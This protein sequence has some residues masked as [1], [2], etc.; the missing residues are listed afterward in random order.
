MQDFATGKAAALRGSEPKLTCSYLKKILSPQVGR[1]MRLTTILLLTACLHVGA[2]GVTQTVSLSEKNAP[3]IKVMNEIEHQTGYA[4]FYK[5]QWLLQAK[6][7]TIKAE[8]IPLKQALDLC[9]KDQPFTYIISGKN[10]S[11]TPKEIEKPVEKP[12]IDI[13]GKITDKDGNPLAGANVK[14]K[15]SNKGVTTNADGSF[16]LKEV[17]ENSVLEIS[18]VGFETVFF[19]L[20]GRTS[21]VVTLNPKSSFLDETIVIAYGTTTKRFETGNISKVS[22]SEIEKQPVTNPLLALQGRVPGLQITQTSGLQ[23]SG[24]IV[25]IQ[26]QNSLQNGSNPLYVVDGVPVT[27]EIP[28]PGQTFGPLGNS[29]EVDIKNPSSGRGNTLNF[30][31]PSDIESIEVL[32]DADAT[33]IYGSR[34]AN[35]AILITTKKGKAGKPSVSANVQKGWGEVGHFMDLLNTE[36]YFEMRNEAFINDSFIPSADNAA[37]GQSIYAPDLKLWDAARYTDWQKTLLGGSAEYTNVSAS[38]SGGTSAIQYLF[39]ANYNKQTTVFPGNFSDAMGSMHLSLSNNDVNQKFHFQI[40]SNYSID[41]NKLPATDLTN[42]ALQLAPNAPALYNADGSLNWEP[43]SNGNSTFINPLAMPTYQL[44]ST[45]T[46]NLITSTNLSYEILPGLKIASTLGYTNLQ[47]TDM[48]RESLLALKPEDRSL[49]GNQRYTFYGDSKGETWIVEPQITYRKIIN[50]NKLD[51]LIGSTFQETNKEAQALLGS[52]FNNDQVMAIPTAAT[53]LQAQGYLK[54]RYKYNALF[55]RLNYT[56]AD[57]Y[58]LNLTGRR[59][60]SSRF[61]ANNRF[62]NFY[63]V[64]AAWIITQEA[65]LRNMQ[66]L[67]FLS[68]A[69]LKGN[70][71]TVG[72][73]QIGDYTYLTLYNIRNS[74]VPYQAT[75]GL[76]PLGISNP[77]LEW[78]ET[79]KL[80][81]GID[82]GFLNDRVLLTANYSRNKSSNQLLSY[83]LPQLTGRNSVLL[84]FPATVQ[85][86]TWE[87]SLNTE[88]IKTKNLKW[89][90]SINLSIPRN[91]LISFPNLESSTYSSVYIVGE[92]ISFQRLYHYTGVDATTGQYT[93]ADNHGNPT[94]SPV[95]QTDRTALISKFSKYYGGLQNNFQF[96]SFELSFFIQFVQ[97]IAPSTAFG[98]WFTVPGE[99]YTFNSAGNQPVSVLNRWQKPG[100]NA[101]VQRFMVS[102]RPVARSFSN[103]LGSDAYYSDASYARLKNVALSWE[104]PSTLRQKARLQSC[105]LYVECQNLFT[106][107]KYK[108][109]DPETLSFSTL[110]PLRVLTAGL[111]VKF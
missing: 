86:T 57:K 72:S 17:D 18:Y 24:V 49:P 40:K 88:N 30:L 64:G 100:D 108:G 11:I 73:D 48:R 46:Y 20:Q 9:F 79:K 80:S 110:P 78:E 2:K 94:L 22:A 67:S 70:Y 14:I 82:L 44:Y 75:T 51:A 54:S 19:A 101:N 27:S 92:P 89:S 91:K 103:A 107:T 6:K 69:K 26:G 106:V 37:S 10:I 29:G 45:K 39:G 66:S 41:N 102:N 16:T 58:I 36:Q 21:L 93:V 90:T 99:F 43:N 76:S 7:V 105:R 31:N 83:A 13:S 47:S 53:T 85:N 95:F 52:G 32:K 35:G 77:Y 74:P 65:F 62:N 68:F 23:G 56:W 104:V 87:L 4:F 8:N 38:I 61:G 81:I 60:G 25:R 97:Q 71:G 12:V 111:Q 84:N 3:L 15:G 1:I 63:S 34:A 98:F 59:D 28:F 109:L 5:S 50:K 33:S 96:R 42:I 55:S